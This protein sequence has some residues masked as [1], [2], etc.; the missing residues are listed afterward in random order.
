MLVAMIAEV[1]GDDE[2]MRLYPSVLQWDF[3]SQSQA[4][5]E[6]TGQLCGFS[7]KTAGTR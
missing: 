5:S 3:T 4:I 7:E 6:R 1:A 2:I